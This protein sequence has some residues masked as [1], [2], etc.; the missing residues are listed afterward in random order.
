MVTSAP[1]APGA[2]VTQTLTVDLTVSTDIPK[3]LTVVSTV[4]PTNDGFMGLGGKH[5]PEFDATTGASNTHVYWVNA[6][7]AGTELNDEKMNP[8]GG[9]ACTYTET[10]LIPAAPNADVGTGGTGVATAADTNTTIHVHRGILGDDDL[11]GGKS[12]LVGTIHRWQNPVAKIVVTV[13]Q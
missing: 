13:G 11:T 3:H 5:I 12:D 10:G 7:D 9:S 1:L 4:L 8:D 6:Y 2:S